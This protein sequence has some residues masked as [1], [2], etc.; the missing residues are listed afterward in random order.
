MCGIREIKG[1]G[2]AA[3]AIRLIQFDMSRSNCIRQTHPPDS[4]VP[5]AFDAAT[6]EMAGLDLPLNR[7][8]R[9]TKIILRSKGY[10]HP[11][12]R[13]R[14]VN[15]GCAVGDQYSGSLGLVSSKRT[16][17]VCCSISRLPTHFG[18]DGNAY[19]DWLEN[20]R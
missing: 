2:S 20:V 1:R 4:S 15:P 9:A 13:A 6:F 11:V 7:Q 10:L 19:F 12:L 18:A 3:V 8:D 17:P 16:L 5:I 14:I